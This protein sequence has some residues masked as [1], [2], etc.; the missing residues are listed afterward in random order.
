MCTVYT[1]PLSDNGWKVRDGCL[2]IDINAV[3]PP[4]DDAAWDLSLRNV[5]SRTEP[6]VLSE[7]HA[8]MSSL[9]LSSVYSLAHISFGATYMILTVYFTSVIN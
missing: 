7:L 4:R 8:L 9:T 1:Y 5:L 3:L 2:E 6:G